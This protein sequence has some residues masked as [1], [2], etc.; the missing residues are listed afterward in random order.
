MIV[1]MTVTDNNNNN[2]SN[3]SNINHINSNNAELYEDIKHNYLPMC[4]G[5]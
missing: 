5:M 3:N 1:I 2:N 4:D